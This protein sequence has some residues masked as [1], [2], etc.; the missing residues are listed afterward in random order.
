MTVDCGSGLTLTIRIVLVEK[1]H[2]YQFLRLYKIEMA[3]AK[4]SIYNYDFNPIKS[5]NTED[6]F[7]LI[8]TLF[9]NFNFNNKFQLKYLAEKT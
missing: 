3:R 9:K 8:F 6:S 5:K 7:K 1:S 4:K 2:I